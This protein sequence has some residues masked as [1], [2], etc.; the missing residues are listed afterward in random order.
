MAFFIDLSSGDAVNT[1]FIA[2]IAARNNDVVAYLNDNR[3]AVIETRENNE[4]A[5]QRI[6]THATDLI[7]E[8][9]LD[10]RILSKKQAEDKKENTRKGK[11]KK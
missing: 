10:V 9:V 3:V 11:K 4:S 8:G 7:D 6:L 5:Q 1:N 2:R